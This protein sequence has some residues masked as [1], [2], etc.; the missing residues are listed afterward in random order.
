MCND[1]LL[2]GQ[3]NENANEIGKNDQKSKGEWSYGWTGRKD[4]VCSM[5][6]RKVSGTKPCLRVV[7]L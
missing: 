1:Q 4:N 7:D 2:T 5:R 3:V 6:V